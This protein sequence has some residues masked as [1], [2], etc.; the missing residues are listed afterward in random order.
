MWARNYYALVAGLADVSP[1]AARPPCGSADF[2]ANLAE[3]VH[4]DDAKLLRLLQ[5][6]RD[7]R[8]LITLLEKR[9]RPFVPGGAYGR[10]ELA[11][12]IENPETLPD[13]MCD[14]IAAHRADELMLPELAADDRLS[15]LFFDLAAGHPNAFI[16]SWF[17]F[18]RALRNVLAALAVRRGMPH[19][20]QREPEQL[21]CLESVLVCRT[22][23]EERLLTSAAPDFGLAAELPWI[24]RVLELPADDLV[25]RERALD[26]LRWDMLEELTV[27]SHFQIETLLAFCVRLMLVERWTRLD[28]QTGRRRLEQLVQDLKPGA[29]AAA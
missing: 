17:S 10:G 22:G 12:E 23:V 29:R 4:P 20:Q 7:N 28:P 2:I 5:L 26:L 1:D 21:K 19:L 24:G 3:L 11:A 9:D 27:L 14:Y 25:G 18:E 13:Y 6:P 8:N 15:W 16:A